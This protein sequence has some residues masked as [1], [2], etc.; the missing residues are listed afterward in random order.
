M[1][2]QGQSPGRSTMKESTAKSIVSVS[3]C[4]SVDSQEVD[5]SVCLA[6]QLPNTDE[7][8]KKIDKKTP[9]SHYTRRQSFEFGHEANRTKTSNIRHRN[10]PKEVAKER[11][12]GKENV[13]RLI[14]AHVD[15]LR[16]LFRNGALSQKWKLVQ[17]PFRD[18]DLSP[19]MC[20]VNIS[21]GTNVTTEQSEWIPSEY[22]DPNRICLSVCK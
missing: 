3:T 18:K 17:W 14:H 8:P 6:V 22:R 4:L 5:L 15:G 7:W 2:L 12:L 16:S 19:F 11:W 9:K 13:F 21:Y 10:F 1:E 20:T